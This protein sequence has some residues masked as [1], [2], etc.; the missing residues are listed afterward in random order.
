MS[1]V[2]SKADLIVTEPHSFVSD[3]ECEDVVD[4]G[5]RFGVSLGSAEHLQ[6]M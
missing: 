3:E 1:C 5:L 2:R 4:E 6:C